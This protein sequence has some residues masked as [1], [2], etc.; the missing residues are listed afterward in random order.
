MGIRQEIN[1][2]LNGLCKKAHVWGRYEPAHNKQAETNFVKKIPNMAWGTLGMG[3]G[4][5]KGVWDRTLGEGSQGGWKDYLKEGW[6]AGFNH[7]D[8]AAAGMVEGIANAIPFVEQKTIPSFV[9]FVRDEKINAGMEPE[10]ADALRTRGNYAGIGVTTLPAMKAIGWTG[11][12]LGNGATRFAGLINAG[13]RTKNLMQIA[14][15]SAPA[16]SLTAVGAQ[17]AY[18]N[19]A[20]ADKAEASNLILR[21][22]DQMQGL[23]PSSPEYAQK[24]DA[25]KRLSEEYG[26]GEFSQLIPPS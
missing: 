24:Y 18:Q 15:Q 16:A 19:G 3:A 6:N 1:T 23:N 17:R 2:A 14:G 25:L 8:M 21:A 7:G 5:A 11:K 13:N 12:I 9:D 26:V 20:S 22:L 10:V 4:L